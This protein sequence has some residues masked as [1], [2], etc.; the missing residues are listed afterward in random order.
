MSV[1]SKPAA[2]VS[3]GQVP[4]I[5]AGDGGG[6]HPTQALLD[7]FSIHQRFG[8]L[9][10]TIHLT[11]LGD[12]R[13]GR[14]VHSLVQMV[15]HFPNISLSLVSP[16]NLR[17]PD[18]YLDLLRRRNCRFEV[19]DS[20]DSVLGQTDVLYQTRVQK[21]R[22]DDLEEYA[23]SKGQFIVTP[24]VMSRLKSTGILMHPFPRVDEITE[25]VD[26]D[27]RAW[28]FKQPAM[29]VRAR[30]ALLGLVMGKH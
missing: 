30:M 29:G 14:T 16:P 3:S 26:A 2:S 25:E 5:N 1:I 15:S 13:F 8:S 4:I 17:M 18:G 6:E 12:L 21:E 11:M 23:R 10:E 22:F 28:Y 24:D 7:L 9:D 27:S 20:L 19:L